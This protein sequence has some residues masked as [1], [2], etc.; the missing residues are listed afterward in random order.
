MGEVLLGIDGAIG[1]EV[2]IILEVQI[3]FDHL[4]RLENIFLSEEFP[5]MRLG[6]DERVIPCWLNAIDRKKTNSGPFD[7]LWSDQV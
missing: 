1:K 5:E 6:L 7:H 4:D 2:S 3:I